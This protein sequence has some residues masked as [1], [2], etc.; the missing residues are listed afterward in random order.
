MKSK[1]M[2]IANTL[3]INGIGRSAAMIKAWALVKQ[4]ALDVK[5]AGVTHGNRQ[6]A[7]AR[8]KAYPAA[9][10]SIRLEREPGN[11][12]D[13]YAVKVVAAVEGKG[14]YTIGYLPRALALV[15]APLMDAGKAI[16]ARFQAVVGGLDM[17]QFHGLRLGVEI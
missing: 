3:V 11:A 14:E 10:V 8:L 1:V 13:P 17:T 2:I 12:F 7:L 5:A 15:V 9:Q 6:K 16:A 4:S